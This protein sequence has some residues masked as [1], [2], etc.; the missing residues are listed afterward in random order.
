M[1][2]V[3][4]L[5]PGAN[6]ATRTQYEQGREAII[7]LYPGDDPA[8]V[9]MREA[10]LETHARQSRSAAKKR[11]IL[12]F[13]DNAFAVTDWL[14]EH[15][16]RP[17]VAQS[18]WLLAFTRV[19]RKTGEILLSRQEMADILRTSPVNVSRC[20]AELVDIGAITRELR[21]VS[22]RKGPGEVRYILSANI[23]THLPGKARDEAQ[24]SAPVLKVIEGGLM[25]LR[26]RARVV[27]P[28]EQR[29]RAA[30]PAIAAC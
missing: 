13:F 12:M 25:R 22:G 30:Q 2:N 17:K 10:L 20:M 26:R 21:P 4:A 9:R 8:S 28:T 29:S 1:S 7:S 3:V 16:K 14:R 6:R 19:D 18:L 24:A 5:K 27:L 11:F 15:S 23:G